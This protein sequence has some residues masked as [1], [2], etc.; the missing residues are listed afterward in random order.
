MTTEA[1]PVRRGT[2]MASAAAILMVGFVLSRL[3]G[4]VRVSIQAS[5]LGASGHDAAAF[6]T[7]IAIPDFVFT[8]VSGGALASSFIPV[9]TGLL[10][11]GNED[12]AWRFLPPRRLC[13]DM[14]LFT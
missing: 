2:S 5:V 12:G 9:F 6:T 13:L 3:L 4:L 7:A 1:V 8:L 14:S 10:E 11:R